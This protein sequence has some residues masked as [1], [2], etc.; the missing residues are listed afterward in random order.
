MEQLLTRTTSISLSPQSRIQNTTNI[1]ISKTWTQGGS[2]VTYDYPFAIRIPTIPALTNKRLPV[3][4]LLHGN[5]GNG[6]NEIN[7]W[8][9]YLGDSYLLHQLV[10]TMVG[11]LH[12]KL[13]KAPDIE[14]LQDL[15]TQLKG[16]S[17]VDNTK[18]RIIGFSNGAALANRAYVQIDDPGLD[19]ICTIATQFLILCLEMIRFI[20]LLDKQEQLQQNI[21][22]QRHL[23][24]P[25]KFLNIHGT[26][27]TVIPYAGGSH[28]FGYKALE[29]P[30]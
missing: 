18:I 14:M 24:N 13:T 2:S 21:I 25:R 8:E 1:T 17:N 29:A 16:Y 28:S 30:R 20:F 23:T 5:G 12:T 3:A 19:V 15:I 11:T 22:L 6:T 4:I 27:D 9:N 10:M 26:A 7:A